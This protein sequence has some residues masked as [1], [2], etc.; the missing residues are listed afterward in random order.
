M[1]YNEYKSN[2]HCHTVFCDG[3]DTADEIAK[4]ANER[5]FVSI[6]F[7]CHSPLPYPTDWALKYDRIDEYCEKINTL[8]KIYKDSTEILCGIE[9]DVE[10]TSLPLDKFSYVLGSMHTLRVDGAPVPVDNSAKE[11]M[12]GVNKYFGGDIIKATRAYY[13][14][15]YISATRP[16]IDI[17]GHFDLVTK[18]N[19]NNA[20]FDETSKEYLDYA[21]SIL[22]GV[23]DK[24]PDV[25]FEI[26]T[27]AMA[28]TGR[29]VPYP[30]KPLLLRLKERRMRVMVNSDCHDKRYLEIGYDKAFSLLEECG[31]NS[32]WRLRENG[33][34]ELGL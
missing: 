13:D 29:T 17:V 20:L 23:C 14:Q 33:F 21:I 32:V 2:A 31:F 10:S 22:D 16:E 6:G 18:F 19:E 24:R 11:W 5:G 27:G 1:K 15:V 8:K 26:N 9:L 28:R 30:L 3:A 12:D 25:V 4:E 34:E 7:S